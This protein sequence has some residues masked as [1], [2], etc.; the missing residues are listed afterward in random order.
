MILKE[1]LREVENVSVTVDLWSDRK[2]RSYMG[3]TVHY[4]HG[5]ELKSGLLCCL[6]ITGNVITATCVNLW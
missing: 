3:V 2:M 5:N 6:R 1:R 4:L